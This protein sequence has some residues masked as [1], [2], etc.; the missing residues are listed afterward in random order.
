MCLIFRDRPDSSGLRE[1]RSFRGSPRLNCEKRDKKLFLT[2]FDPAQHKSDRRSRSDPSLL[3]P[4]SK[5]R[6][7]NIFPTMNKLLLTLL[8]FL[9]LG[10]FACEKIVDFQPTAYNPKMVIY[11]SLFADSIPGVLL[12][13]TRSYYGWE[14]YIASRLYV[15]GASVSLTSDNQN[16]TLS[17]G[18][19][20]R[21]MFNLWIG[22]PTNY[23]EYAY[24]NQY[25]SLGDSAIRLYEGPEPLKAGETYSF[26]A[27]YE[28]ETITR[29]IYVPQRATNFS[30][31]FR[32]RDTSYTNTY[33]WDPNSKEEVVE[34]VFEALVH[35]TI[36][37][38]IELWHKPI[39]RQPYTEFGYYEYD[40]E[41]GYE[42]Y[43]EDSIELNRMV[44][45]PFQ[46]VIGSKQVTYAAQV[47]S[48]SIRTYSY[49][50]GEEYSYQDFNFTV[51]P[52]EHERIFNGDTLSKSVFV[53]V[54]V[55]HAQEEAIQLSNSLQQQLFSGQDPLSEPIITSTQEDGAIGIIGGFAIT[56]EIELPVRLWMRFQ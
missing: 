4:I 30:V 42:Y 49:D 8:S 9:M 54:L 52:E 16:Q 12:G 33:E 41:T 34:T 24:E 6:Y 10:L 17:L 1:V 40:P 21:N 14:E 44:Y 28:G 46:Q 11:G 22:L 3:T 27:E 5:S 19:F 23:R 13:Q 37:E 25:N 45:S 50:N 32:T 43:V 38:D 56:E 35:Y 20:Q 36:P 26:R 2:Y 15:E 55:S 53:Q 31:E 7:L 29:D 18:S 39:I 51:S 48:A 47:G